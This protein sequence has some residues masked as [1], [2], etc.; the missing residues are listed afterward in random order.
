M[1]CIA[2]MDISIG[3]ELMSWYK[4]L[5]SNFDNCSVSWLFEGIKSRSIIL[6]GR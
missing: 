2:Y 1:Y 4:V 5:G 3:F 6:T